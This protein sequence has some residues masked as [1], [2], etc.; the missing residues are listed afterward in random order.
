MMAPFR[1]FDVKVTDELRENTKRRLILET[2]DIE[3]AVELFD[4]TLARHVRFDDRYNWKCIYCDY[5]TKYDEYLQKELD[6]PVEKRKWWDKGYN[7]AK[8][9]LEVP[10]KW[11]KKT[12]SK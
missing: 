6:I 1:V 3:D 12:I 7:G 10:K 5:K 4:P 8:R 9:R 11:S 2:R